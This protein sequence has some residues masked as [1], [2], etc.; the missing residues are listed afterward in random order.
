[1]KI[2]IHTDFDVNYRFVNI[3]GDSSYNFQLKGNLKI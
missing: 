1:M 2:L 3:S